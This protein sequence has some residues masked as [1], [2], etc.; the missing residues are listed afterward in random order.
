MVLSSW[1]AALCKQLLC[2]KSNCEVLGLWLRAQTRSSSCL[3]AG[4]QSQWC[5]QSG[6]SGR[7]VDGGDV[8]HLWARSCAMRCRRG[9]QLVRLSSRGSIC[10]RS[11]A[12]STRWEVSA[13]A[14]SIYDSRGHALFRSA[15]VGG[16]VLRAGACRDGATRARGRVHRTPCNGRLRLVSL[17][18][19][20]RWLGTALVNI[21]RPPFEL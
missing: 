21:S 19:S 16:G 20:S 14:G 10:S 3:A 7:S 18:N 12:R 9:A 2:F 4:V 6:T 15:R 11:R 8:V 13:K 1:L 17:A 5:C